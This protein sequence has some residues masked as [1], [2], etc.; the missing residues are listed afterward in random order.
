MNEPVKITVVFNAGAYQATHG[1][2]S[3]SDGL[4]AHR[5]AYKCARKVFKSDAVTVRETHPKVWLA[6]PAA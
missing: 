3:G 2:H 5:A 1:N 4:S 6:T